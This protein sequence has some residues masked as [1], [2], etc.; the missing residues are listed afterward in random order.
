MYNVHSLLALF[1]THKKYNIIQFTSHRRCRC[2]RSNITFCSHFSCGIYCALS[3]YLR[4]CMCNVY[5][6][7][8]CTVYIADWLAFHLPFFLVS[9][10]WSYQTYGK[11]FH[12]SLT[13]FYGSN[14]LILLLC[15]FLFLFPFS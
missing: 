3:C 2:R 14:F 12:F 13:L 9:F 7:C 6:S 4:A 11:S 15:F 10:N 8:D 5:V 1:S